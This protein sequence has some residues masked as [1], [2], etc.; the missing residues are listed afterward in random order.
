MYETFLSAPLYQET[1]NSKSS[2]YFLHLK[3]SS[4]R[5]FFV[6]VTA[7]WNKKGQKR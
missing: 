2:N 3:D 7:M 4:E 5:C 1:I 6:P